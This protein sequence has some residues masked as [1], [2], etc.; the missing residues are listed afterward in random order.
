MERYTLKESL[1]KKGFGET[2]LAIDKTTR[3][4]C[5]LKRID[6]SKMSSKEYDSEVVL[7]KIAKR[8]S[9]PNITSYMTGFVI[10]T[11]H[12]YI[13]VSEYCSGNC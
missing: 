4:K 10:G 5:A 11:T 9:H 2:F 12:E 7:I 6:I 8:L 13:L 1:G 3:N